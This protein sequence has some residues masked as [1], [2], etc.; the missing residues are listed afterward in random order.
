MFWLVRMRFPVALPRYPVNPRSSKPLSY[1]VAFSVEKINFS[2]NLWC[3]ISEK[4]GYKCW[5]QI[6]Y[7]RVSR[8]KHSEL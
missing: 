3:F 1:E 4:F 8:R 7:H 5:P 6:L 2:K